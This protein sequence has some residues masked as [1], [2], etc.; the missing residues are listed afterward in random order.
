MVLLPGKLF[1][2]FYDSS[3]RFIWEIYIKTVYS[4]YSGNKT[5]SSEVARE[6]VGDIADVSSNLF[7]V[8]HFKAS[9][10]ESIF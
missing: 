4:M 10:L 3:Y 7:P 5:S 9:C 2:S 6:M 1:F 8:Q